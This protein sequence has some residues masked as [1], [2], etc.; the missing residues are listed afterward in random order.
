[1]PKGLWGRLRN[2]RGTFLSFFVYH[3]YSQEGSKT[4]TPSKKL[5]LEF[6]KILRSFSIEQLSAIVRRFSV[7]S[8]SLEISQN[9]QE[10]T[11]VGI[12]F[13]MKLQ[14][15][16][17]FTENRDSNAGVFVG[18]LRIFYGTAFCRTPPEDSFWTMR[19]CFKTKC[20]ESLQNTKMGSTFHYL[21]L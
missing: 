15:W 10:N 6:S 8:C 21:K 11:C 4:F 5:F 16:G 13:L 17:C 9:L 19:V 7:T 1:M 14:V 2:V 20:F 12:S 18:T 3:Y